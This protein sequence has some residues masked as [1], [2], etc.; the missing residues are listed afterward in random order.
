MDV[1]RKKSTVVG[2]LLILGI[3]AGILSID[4]VIDKPDNLASVS[5]NTN[6]I[7][8]RAFMQFILALFYAAVPIVLYSLFEKINAS[9]TVGFLVFRIIA[10]VLILIGWM[11][12]LLLLNLSQEFIKAGN[13]DLSYFQT[14]DNLLRSGRDLINH[15]AM[16]L[17]LSVGNLIFYY[18]LYQSKLIPGW[19]SIWG[20]VATILSSVL[21]SLLLMFNV[22]NIIT[23]V[24]I[25]LAF[26]T[27]LLEIVLAIWLLV[28][29][30][31]RSVVKKIK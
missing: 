2:V 8:V 14:L 6:P 19:L 4:P 5:I 11:S 12:I 1:F 20:L 7:L 21:A 3:V 31:D 22:I 25:A 28:K 13:P 26:P 27:A 24:Y 15:V 16:P 17:T 18:I 30:F 9:L 29:G 10:V 23:P